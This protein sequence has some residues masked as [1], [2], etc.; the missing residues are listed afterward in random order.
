M[1]LDQDGVVH[2]WGSNSWGQTDV[3]KDIQGNVMHIAAGD[4]HALAQLTDG[5]I[6]AWGR[7]D[8]GQCDVPLN[9]E[10]P[11][12]GVFAGNH[13][14]FASDD[15]Q[16]LI[17]W[18]DMKDP[19]SSVPPG[20]QGPF[21]DIRIG[22]G[23]CAALLDAPGAEA[24]ELQCWGNNN[25]GQCV[26]PSA[27]QGRV[28]RVA[29][30]AEH[31]IVL[32]DDGDLDVWGS[33]NNYPDKL[34]S[35]NNPIIEVAADGDNCIAVLA[36][37]RVAGWP[38]AVGRKL[39]TPIRSIAVTSLHSFYVGADGRVEVCGESY[40]SGYDMMMP[41]DITG[42]AVKVSTSL[43]GV[44]VLLENGEVRSWADLDDVQPN[45]LD[46]A[47]DVAVY[48]NKGIALTETGELVPLGNNEIFI[49]D[50]IQG[51][52]L[53][54]DANADRGMALLDDGSIVSWANGNVVCWAA[55]GEI[56][57]IAVLDARYILETDGTVHAIDI[58]GGSTAV[59]ANCSAIGY[60][61][62]SGAN[63]YVMA[64]GRLATSEV[65][66]VNLDLEPL[67]S[68][69]ADLNGDDVVDGEDLGLV[70]GYWGNPGG[71]A[72][73]NQDGIVNGVDMGLLLAAWGPVQ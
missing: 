38:E 14:S 40:P 7:N 48:S 33:E 52:V 65:H 62:G 36:D 6:V 46:N 2:A 64:M 5:S 17:A 28:V 54:F 49:P 53:R 4:H 35:P 10:F 31:T 59:P 30:G 3:P 29:L 39:A 60:T 13:V 69:V 32:L 66:V 41:A 23:H 21:A 63:Q 42:P 8:F 15:N 72:D 61:E 51:R 73:I 9:I 44:A 12:T 50:S 1:A 67:S 55:P 18:G 71:V 68:S 45:G 37:G 34:I 20:L 11:A 58:P 56:G 24:Y 22:S 43:N 25:R 70:L 26:V 16:Q 57:E 27:S 47:I 19:I